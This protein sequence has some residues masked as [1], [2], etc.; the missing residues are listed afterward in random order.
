MI[1]AKFAVSLRASSVYQIDRWLDSGAPSPDQIAEFRAKLRGASKHDA[2]LAAHDMERYLVY[3]AFRQSD[4]GVLST[5]V[6]EPWMDPGSDQ[7][8]Y[9]YAGVRLYASLPLRFARRHDE[10]TCLRTFAKIRSAYSLP[11]HE[12]MPSLRLIDENLEALQSPMHALG[13]LTPVTLLNISSTFYFYNFLAAD[14][15]RLDMTDTALG[16]VLYK[17]AHGAYPDSLAALV[18]EFEDAVPVDVFD[19]QPLRYERKGEGFLLYSVGLDLDDDKG[20]VWVGSWQGVP[21][22]DIVWNATR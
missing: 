14:D 1:D 15:T 5:Q 10:L 12:A 18:P 20:E 4:R 17:R 2:L 9:F 11:S 8:W 3:Q 21:P 13:L 22:G 7:P 6:F 16:L 19:G